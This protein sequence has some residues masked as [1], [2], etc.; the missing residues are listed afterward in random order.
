MRKVERYW[1]GG[2][3]TSWEIMEEEGR[4]FGV[5]SV[6]KKQR[7][8]PSIPSS[9]WER[10]GQTGLH[11]LGQGSKLCVCFPRQLSL[12]FLEGISH[13]SSSPVLPVESPQV[14]KT[15]NWVEPVW[16]SPAQPKGRHQCWQFDRLF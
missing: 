3:H 11:I 2:E 4:H 7:V 15:K 10:T 8:W 6:E 5:F 13:F 9:P 16:R 12:Q 1:E 14:Q